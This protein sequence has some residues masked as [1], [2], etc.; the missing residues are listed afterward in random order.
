MGAPE[1]LR[2]SNEQ[3]TKSKG[4]NRLTFAVCHKR[5]SKSLYYGQPNAAHCCHP[6]SQLSAHTLIIETLRFYDEYD[7]EYETFFI[8]TK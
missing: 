5:D 2:R 3:K 8:S 6:V 7:N 1:Y 4:K